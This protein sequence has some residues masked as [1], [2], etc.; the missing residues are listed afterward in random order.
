VQISDRDPART[1]RILV[2][3]T[4]V[5]EVGGERLDARMADRVAP[6]LAWLRRSAVTFADFTVDLDHTPPRL[7]EV[8]C[9]PSW[10]LF[11]QLED[12]VYTALLERL[13]P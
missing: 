4:D 9:W 2:A 5:F 1:G 6:V 13:V 12:R 7:L 10:H 11:A 3:G 8:S